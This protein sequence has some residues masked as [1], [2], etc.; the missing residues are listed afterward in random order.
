MRLFTIRSCVVASI[1]V[2]AIALLYYSS[3]SGSS[4][5]LHSVQARLVCPGEFLP[6]SAAERLTHFLKAT[7]V[8]EVQDAKHQQD[9]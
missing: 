8:S 1:R 2:Q 4:R 5:R 9:R 3:S 7:K 6:R